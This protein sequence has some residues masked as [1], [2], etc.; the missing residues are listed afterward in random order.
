[1]L[2]D[3]RLR[4]RIHDPPQSERLRAPRMRHEQPD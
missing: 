3:F 4:R 1:L 2:F